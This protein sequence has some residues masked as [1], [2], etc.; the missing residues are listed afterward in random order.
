[1]TDKFH[2]RG[3]IIRARTRAS[4]DGGWSHDGLVEQD[5]AY[6]VDDHTFSAPG[7]SATREEALKII[8]AHGKQLIDDLLV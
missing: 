8:L 1:L 5:L 4:P 7:K 2:Y 3:F 6:T